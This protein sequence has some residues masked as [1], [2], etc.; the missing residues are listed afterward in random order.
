MFPIQRLLSSVYSS[1]QMLK[2][3][4]RV[5]Q[6]THEHF[7]SWTDAHL[8]RPRSGYGSFD[9]RQKSVGEESLYFQLKMNTTGGFKCPTDK[10]PKY[11][12]QQAVGLYLQ[13]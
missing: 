6:R 1:Q 8:Q 11:W 9:R 12:G 3:P 10:N 5:N 2:M 4:S 13:N 7:W